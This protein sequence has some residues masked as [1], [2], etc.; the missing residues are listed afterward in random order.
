MI[1]L[2]KRAQLLKPSPILM[3]AAR[4]GELKAAGHDVISLTIGEPDWQ[5]YDH[6]KEVAIAAIRS[7]KS[8]YTPANGIPELRK[9]IAEQTSAD[10]GLSYDP[11]QVTVSSGAK[12]V[13]FAALQAII[14]PGDEVLLFAPFWASYTTMVELAD[15]VPRIVVCDESVD[16]KLTPDLLRK[17]ITPK[18]KAILLNSPSNPT[19]KV[20]S[21]EEL[22]ALAAVL[23]DYPRVAII[24]DDIYNRLSFNEKLSPHLLHVA[25]DLRERVIILNGASKSY[26]MTGWRLGWALGAKD[27]I[28]AMSSYQSQSVSC[29]VAASQ[30]AAVDAILNSEKDVAGTVVMLKSR[31]DILITELEKIDGVR[32]AR[33]DGAFYLWMSVQKYIGKSH[34]GKKM[35]TSNELA[36]ALLNSQMVAVVPGID[37]GLDGYFRL[38]FAL[39]A[40]KGREAVGRMAKFFASLT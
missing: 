14:D 15:G 27:I 18:T 40:E 5:T 1:T 16:F 32:V 9:A 4:A 30:Y 23:R 25:P 8:K 37:F 10:L 6:I 33:P 34:E 13:L 7:G 26:A 39:D 21:R 2:A 3:L 17:S 28:N 31:R 36:Q 20:Y 35:V 12:F 11:S 22:K 29:A 24:S 38:S 19:G